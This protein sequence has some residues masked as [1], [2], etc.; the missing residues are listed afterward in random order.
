VHD[1]LPSRRER[2][3]DYAKEPSVQAKL[4]KAEHDGVQF[5]LAPSTTTELTVG[6]VKGGEKHYENNRKI[7]AWLDTH[8]KN[9]LDLP[10]PFMGNILGFPSKHSDVE[11]HHFV[12]R[13]T[14]VMNSPTFADFLKNKDTPGSAWSDIDQS[15]VVHAGQV[16]KEF[17]A[18]ENIAKLPPEKLKK[19][20][21]AAAFCKTFAS[22]E[23]VCPDATVFRQHFSTAMEYGEASIKKIQNGANPRKNDRGRY[24]DFQLLFYLADPNF[25]ILTSDG[26]SND[27]VKSPQRTR[28]VG[29]DTF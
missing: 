4:E 18:L 26:Y 3:I 9:V 13:I 21:F 24:C 27:I 11:K 12:D 19:V 15:A 1:H 7:F 25:T 17:D 22:P 5:A 23:G 29:L 20:D 28:I 6:L 16:N 14:I 10:R 8:S 2:P